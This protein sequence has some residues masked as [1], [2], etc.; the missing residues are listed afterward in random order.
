[1]LRGISIWA[2]DDKESSWKNIEKELVAPTT[3]KDFIVSGIS[4]KKCSLYYGPI[5]TH[6]FHVFGSL[7]RFLKVKNVWFIPQYG[8]T[9]IFYLGGNPLLTGHGNLK[10]SVH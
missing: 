5:F 7:E 3:L 8:I 4:A 9:P 6:T 2:D 10:A 1:M